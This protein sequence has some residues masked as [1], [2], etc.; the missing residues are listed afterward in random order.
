MFDIRLRDHSAIGISAR[1]HCNIFP[2]PEYQA[3][4]DEDGDVIHAQ[5]LE[6]EEF[7]FLTIMISSN[8]HDAEA[9]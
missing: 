7:D 9:P 1:L 3:V 8:M 5:F 6:F 2:S 4:S